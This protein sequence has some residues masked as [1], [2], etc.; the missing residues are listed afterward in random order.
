MQF[1][2]GDATKRDFLP[3]SFDVIYSRDTI[4]HIRDKEALFKNFYV[5]VKYGANCYWG[6]GG[7]GF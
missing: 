6:G 3:E 5:I 2:I 4:L 1:E 7:V